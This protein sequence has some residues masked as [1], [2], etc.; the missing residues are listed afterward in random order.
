MGHYIYG[1]VCISVALLPRGTI[2]AQE[3]TPSLKATLEKRAVDYPQV[4]AKWE[5]E[6]TVNHDNCDDSDPFVFQLEKGL[7][8]SLGQNQELWIQG[9]SCRVN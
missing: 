7:L 8:N 9:D 4:H 3:A 5:A 1:I 2:V 6:Y